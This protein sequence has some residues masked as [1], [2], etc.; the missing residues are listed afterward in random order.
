MNIIEKIRE[1]NL[2]TG[3]YVVIG[4]GIMDVLGIRKAHDIDISVLPSLHASLRATGDWSEE[5]R[6]EK[7][8]LIKDGVDINP[9]LSWSDYDTTTGEA[10][11]SATRIDGIDF[12]NLHE[13][14]KFKTAL[15]RDKDL[16]DIELIDMY[17]KE[18]GL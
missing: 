8:F 10:I 17:I 4:S 6:Y 16:A 1:L 12:M 2:P 7:I 3:E 5:I 11:A 18:H 14:R 13:L 9:H 15:G